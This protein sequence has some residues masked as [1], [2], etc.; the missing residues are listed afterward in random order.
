[1][2]RNFWA[3]AFVTFLVV[4][5]ASSQDHDLNQIMGTARQQ[6]DR[7]EFAAAQGSLRRA[8]MVV[9]DR[10]ALNI[11]FFDVVAKPAASFTNYTLRENNHYKAGEPILLY[12]EPTGY[13]FRRHGEMLRFGVEADFELID[14]NGNVLGGKKKFQRSVIE[15]REP[16]FE[17]FTNITYNFTGI[18]PGKYVVRTVL[19]DIVNQDEAWFELPFEIR[20]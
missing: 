12:V 2:F 3:V 8:M 4:S 6:I 13:A 16:I 14:S 7:G 19:H 17:F 20:K 15:G 5:P 1:M 10:A 11:N 18:Q 9:S